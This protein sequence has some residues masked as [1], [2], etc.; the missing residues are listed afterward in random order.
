MTIG[1]FIKNEHNPQAI[2]T[3][4]DTVSADIIHCYAV[5]PSSVVEVL[6]ARPNLK[7]IYTFWLGS[8]TDK[9]LGINAN[10]NAQARLYMVERHTNELL[11][12]EKWQWDTV[13]HLFSPK[14]GVD[15]WL[16]HQ[17]VKNN[18]QAFLA[19]PTEDKTR[20]YFTEFEG[21]AEL[22]IDRM[23]FMSEFARRMHALGFRACVAN[24]STDNLTWLQKAKTHGL[25]DTLLD[26]GG[27]I[28][29]QQ[30]HLNEPARYADSLQAL[31]YGTLPLV[32]TRLGAPVNGA[33]F[34]DQ[35][36]AIAP[37]FNGNHHACLYGYKVDE[38]EYELDGLLDDVRAVLDTQPDPQPEPEPEPPSGSVSLP[39]DFIIRYDTMIDGVVITI[40]QRYVKA[41][42][43]DSAEITRL[44]AQV[45]ALQAKID[46]ALT[47]L[48]T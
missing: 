7:V 15:L 25:L 36:R 17:N 38:T 32:A 19:L 48:K 16:D 23:L 18:M 22:N 12:E 47:I 20:L 43:A 2:L 3:A 39:G 34:W 6:Q 35:L 29:Y 46:A 13:G 1:L 27:M 33:A 11:P 41:G 42:Q 44:K 5:L 31:G 45:A 8:E 26:Y 37:T 24:A 28:G 9:Y 4:I 10:W 30:M 21:V 14:V 40:E